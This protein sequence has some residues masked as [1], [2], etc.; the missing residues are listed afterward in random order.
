MKNRGSSLHPPLL[1][2]INYAYG[3]VSMRIFIQ[4]LDGNAWDGF[5]TG[6]KKPTPT[7]GDKKAKVERTPAERKAATANAKE[8]NKIFVGME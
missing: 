3:K 7:K 8:L 2:G 4:N 5:E 6:W 1:E